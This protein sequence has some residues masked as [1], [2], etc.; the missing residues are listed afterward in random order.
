MLTRK[1]ILD[2]VYDLSEEWLSLQ[3]DP[4]IY[5]ILFDPSEDDT[6]KAVYI[7]QTFSGDNSYIPNDSRIVLAHADIRESLSLEEVGL[8]DD[9]RMIDSE[10]FSTIQD[11][12]NGRIDEAINNDELVELED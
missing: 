8:D 2:R 4:G 11:E 7:T 9:K 10:T 12:T 3:T 1:Q 6:E 5:K